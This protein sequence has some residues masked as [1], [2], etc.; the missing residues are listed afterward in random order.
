MKEETAKQIMWPGEDQLPVLV[1]VGDDALQSQGSRID[2]KNFSME[3]FWL[4]PD[5]EMRLIPFSVKGAKLVC[6]GTLGVSEKRMKTV[7]DND[8][9]PTFLL[10]PDWEWLDDI[11]EDRVIDFNK[12][13]NC[14][15]IQPYWIVANSD[16]TCVY[17]FILQSRS[18]KY[19][20]L[21]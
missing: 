6:C 19:T 10:E 16:S 5:M 2:P 9:Y 3:R 15:Y 8:E 17:H 4:S 12:I 20:I 21:E 7:S 14:F 13:R 18:T 11:P 1:L